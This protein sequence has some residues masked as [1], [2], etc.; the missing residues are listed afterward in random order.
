[1]SSATTK[2]TWSTTVPHLCKLYLEKYLVK[3]HG[4]K[5]LEDSSFYSV[6][7][8]EKELVTPKV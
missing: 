7:S 6:Y 1:M 4:G 5:I 8:S 3:L 2:C